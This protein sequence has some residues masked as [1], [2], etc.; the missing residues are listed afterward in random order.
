MYGTM[1]YIAVVI[2]YASMGIVTKLLKNKDDAE[3]IKPFPSFHLLRRLFTI[4]REASSTNRISRTPILSLIRISPPLIQRT[5][6][7]KTSLTK[8]LLRALPI[9]DR[10]RANANIL[11]TTLHNRKVVSRTVLTS[12]LTIPKLK[13][14]LCLPL[15]CCAPFGVAGEAHAEVFEGSGDSK[16]LLGFDVGWVRAFEHLEAAGDLVEGDLFGEGA[17]VPDVDGES[18]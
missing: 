2:S 13:Q 14:S 15:A 11:I 16:H 12:I 4:D 9:R 8:T 10:I 7:R 6:P 5:L 17:V 3:I 18:V 1:N